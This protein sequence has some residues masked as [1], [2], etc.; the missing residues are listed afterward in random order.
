MKVVRNATPGIPARNCAIRSSMWL[1]D[2]FAAHSSEHAFIDVLKRHVD[3]ARDLVALRDRLDQFVAP[4]R[5]M[6]VE[7]ANPEI[8]LDLFDLA[9]AARTRSARATNRPAG[10]ARLSPPTNPFRNRSCPG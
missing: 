1:A 7:K 9:Q 4:M 10:A 3:I 2:R 5:R 6:G 8:A